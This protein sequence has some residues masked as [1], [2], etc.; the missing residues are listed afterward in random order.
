VEKPSQKAITERYRPQSV[1]VS[2]TETFS[3][4]FND[5]RLGQPDH[6]EFLEIAVCPDVV[7]ALEEIYLH[8]P[9]HKILE[10]GKDPDISFRHHISI[11]IPEVPYITEKVKSLRLPRQRA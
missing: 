10:S 6:S 7:I 5:I 8:S 3:G 4:Y 2:E 11:F 1:T 9:V